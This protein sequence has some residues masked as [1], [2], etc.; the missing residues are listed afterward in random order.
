MEV[1]SK[2]WGWYKVLS[3]GQGYALKEIIVRPGQRL[4]KQ[5]HQHRSEVWV[6]VQGK[7]YAEI[8]GHIYDLKPGKVVTI[9]QGAVHR[10]V[11]DSSDMQLVINETW[12]GDDLRE[13][14]ITRYEDDYNR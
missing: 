2:P 6:C 8:G 13:D 11:N 12:L 9:H 5:S 10:L 14:D 1:V 4:S 3:S 7:G